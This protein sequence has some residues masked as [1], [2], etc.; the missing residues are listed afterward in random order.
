MIIIFISVHSEDNR[1]NGLPQ[2][3]KDSF[4]MTAL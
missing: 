3:S 4:A 2:E 1:K